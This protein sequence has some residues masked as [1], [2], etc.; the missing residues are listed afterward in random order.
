MPP[1]FEKSWLRPCVLYHYQSLQRVSSGDYRGS[2]RGFGEQGN[3]VPPPPLKNP[4]YAPVYCIITKVCSA[5][6]VVTIEGLPGVLGNKGTLAK[7]RREQG[8]ISQ[9]LGTGEQ[10]SKNYN[11]KTFG[12]CVGTWEH[13]VILEGN[14]GT[15][16][17]PGRPSLSEKWATVSALQVITIVKTFEKVF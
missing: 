9:F 7:Y 17:P 15:R 1:P 11:T 4:G 3:I 16:T 12:K 8:N 14:K 6:Q 13:R 5:S 2:P 10:N